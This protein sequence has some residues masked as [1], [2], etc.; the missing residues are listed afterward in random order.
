S[1]AARRE[2]VSAIHALHVTPAGTEGLDK[3]E[4]CAGGVDT[5]EV[6]PHTMESR[7]VPG[8]FL[9]GELL[10]V[11]GRLGGYNLHWAWASGMAAGRAVTGG[12]QPLTGCKKASPRRAR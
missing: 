10:D 2:I 3:A 5:A 7:L 11:T 12:A 4:A 1:R 6:D 8:L 9:I